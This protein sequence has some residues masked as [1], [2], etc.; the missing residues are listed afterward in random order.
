MKLLFLIFISCVSSALGDG[1]S[2]PRSTQNRDSTSDT[3]LR[4]TGVSGR[5][6]GADWDLESF[7]VSGRLTGG[8]A[9]ATSQGEGGGERV[10]VISS[11]HTKIDGS[12]VVATGGTSGVATNGDSNVDLK[13][14]ARANENRGESR[15]GA[16]ARGNTGSASAGSERTITTDKETFVGAVGASAAVSLGEGVGASAGTGS[17]GKTNRGGLGVKSNTSVEGDVAAASSLTASGVKG[18]QGRVFGTGR[19]E[20]FGVSLFGDDDDEDN[21]KTG[22]SGEA[23]N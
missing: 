15:S 19:S 16:Y 3:G 23:D 21:S 4:A 10:A 12:G 17:A 14:S 11:S 13:S 22:S 18:V 20:S 6:R 8:K 7:V 5:L 1:T 2:Q 9:G